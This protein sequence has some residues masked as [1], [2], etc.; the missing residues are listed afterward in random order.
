MKKTNRQ[1]KQ[2]IHNCRFSRIKPNLMYLPFAL[3]AAL[4]LQIATM[5]DSF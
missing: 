5:A 4:F 1:T 3:S 2:L